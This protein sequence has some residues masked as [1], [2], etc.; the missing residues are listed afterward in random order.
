MVVKIMNM[1]EK[2]ESLDQSIK[3][4]TTVQDHMIDRLE[5]KGVSITITSFGIALLTIS[6]ALS[7]L[8][9][10]EEFHISYF[11]IAGSILIIM[12]SIVIMYGAKDKR[13]KLKIMSEERLRQLEIRSKE[14]IE[15]KIISSK[16]RIEEKIISS[17]ES[18][19]QH[20]GD[21]KERN[22]QI[23]DKNGKSL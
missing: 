4:L 10:V 9:L 15:E 21:S 16:E 2:I 3:L 11:T 8:K 18:N 13:L 7:S 14:R 19:T 23:A 22:E 17:K 20:V 5:T 1:E 6:F 12:G